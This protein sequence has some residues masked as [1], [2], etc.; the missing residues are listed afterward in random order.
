MH[1]WIKAAVW[2]PV[3]CGLASDA[4]FK[5]N[6]KRFSDAN[7]SW[8]QLITFGSVGMNDYGREAQKNARK[9]G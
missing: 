7:D 4:E 2:T 1:E 5:Q 8:T 9:V 6:M 3:T